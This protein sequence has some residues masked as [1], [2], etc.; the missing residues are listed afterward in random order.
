MPQNRAARSGEERALETENFT[1]NNSSSCVAARPANLDNGPLAGVPKR[2]A[3]RIAVNSLR[4]AVKAVC[5]LGD[6]KDIREC[7]YLLAGV[8]ARVQG[9]GG[10]K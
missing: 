10:G 1:H 8:L 7:S 3:R 2:L 6:V 4:A 5:R 9:N